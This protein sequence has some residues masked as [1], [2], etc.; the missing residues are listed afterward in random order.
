MKNG[1]TKSTNAETGLTQVVCHAE[2]DP[3]KEGY[4]LL[5]NFEEQDEEFMLHM[6]LAAKAAGAPIGN[7]DAIENYKKKDG[8]EKKDGESSLV[9]LRQGVA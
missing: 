2:N 7:D 3:T 8:E 4:D 6:V 5:Q 9:K 1:L